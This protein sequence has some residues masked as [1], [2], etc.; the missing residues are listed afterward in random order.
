MGSKTHK[1]ATSKCD[2]FIFIIRR[3]HIRLFLQTVY[4]TSRIKDKKIIMAVLI[5]LYRGIKNARKCNFTTINFA[6]L[7]QNLLWGSNFETR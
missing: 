2:N 7:V 1:Q 3:S 4:V 6:R 5:F